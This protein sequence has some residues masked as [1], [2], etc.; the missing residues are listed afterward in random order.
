[1]VLLLVGWSIFFPKCKHYQILVLLELLPLAQ[2]QIPDEDLKMKKVVESWDW[3]L[4]LFFSREWSKNPA[5]SSG[6]RNLT[7]N[8]LH[9]QLSCLVTMETA[10]NLCQLQCALKSPQLK[11]ERGEPSYTF[12]CSAGF[13]EHKGFSTA[14]KRKE[15]CGGSVKLPHAVPEIVRQLWLLFTEG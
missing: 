15:T 6:I 4:L 14:C 8:K 10:T 5:S 11:A 2:W 13:L 3:I 9:I 7:M 1:M 12:S